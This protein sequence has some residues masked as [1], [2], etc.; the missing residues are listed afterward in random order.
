MHPMSDADNDADLQGSEDD[1]SDIDERPLSDT[2][3]LLNRLLDIIESARPVP[4]ST[5]AMIN[6]E[7]VMA[8][9]EQALDAVPRDVK[10][11]RW[12]LKEREGFLAKAQSEADEILGAARAW[13]GRMVERSELVKAAEARAARIIEDAEA[14]ARRL[15]L[16]VEDYC[17]QKLGSFEIVLERTQ[18]LVA[19]GRERLQ[20]RSQRLAEPGPTDPFVDD[21]PVPGDAAERAMFDQDRR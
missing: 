17:D 2:E 19:Q 13:P 8:L 7:E 16:E 10:E 14:Q 9:L 21:E 5:S 3:R 20:L 6:R 11:S 12:L 1:L 15:R 4:L 18:R